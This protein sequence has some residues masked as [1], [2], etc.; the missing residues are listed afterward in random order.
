MGKRHHDGQSAA[1]AVAR[2]EER[3]TASSG[4]DPLELVL[5]RLVA[6]IPGARSIPELSPTAR[7]ARLFDAAATDPSTRS[8]VAE[9][10]AL[11]ERAL[12]RGGDEAFDAIFEA[13][14]SRVRKSDK[15]QFFTPSAVVRFLVRAVAVRAGERMIDPACGSGAFVAEA[16]RAGADACGVDIDPRAARVARLRLLLLGSSFVRAP[17]EKAAARS[18]RILIGDGLGSRGKLPRAGKGF[19]LVLANPPFAGVATATGFAVAALAPRVER[20]VLFVERALDLLKPGGRLG[21]I[22]P[23]GKLAG[24]SWSRFRHFLHERARIGAVVS[25]PKETFLPHTSQRT[26]AI[27]AFKRAARERPRSDEPILLGASER[28]CRDLA[29][30][31]RLDHDLDELARAVASQLSF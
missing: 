1:R 13:L 29:G 5:A 2:I 6:R 15:G 10:D 3:L 20:D 18:G 12:A 24:S 16:A 8:L 23:H 27:F 25:L 30:E 19:D 17:K 28:P 31:P 7:Q 9:V 22:L 11:L 14:S 21:I 4:L 26:A